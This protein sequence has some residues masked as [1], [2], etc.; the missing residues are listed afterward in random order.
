MKL[1]ILSITHKNPTWIN[2]GFAYYYK[3][4]RP[5]CKLELVEIS[6][7]KRFAKS[8]KKAIVCREGEKLIAARNAEF[9]IA[10][11][12]E[13]QSFSTPLLAKNLL[14]WQQKYAT[15]DVLIG[16]PDGLS[17]ACL[18]KADLKWSLSPLTFPHFLV[19]VLIAE[20][21]YRA[22]SLIYHHPYHR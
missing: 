4:L 8:A 18:N 16:G 7:E 20:Q 13:G 10:L 11:D 19:R 22:F 17:E 21:L 3:R 5:W 14:H 15:I 1:R 6:A 2:D 9:T 12:V